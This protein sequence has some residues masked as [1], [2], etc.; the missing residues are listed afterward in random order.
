MRKLVFALLGLWIAH[1]ASAGTVAEFRKAKRAAETY[2]ATANSLKAYV[3]GLGQGM[4]WANIA[5]EAQ[6]EKKLFCP[7]R[8]LALSFD[9]YSS[10]L[11]RE[12]AKPATRD[13]DD[14]GLLLLQGLVDTFP[15]G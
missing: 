1:Y 6:G 8:K 2:P 9:N 3:G 13:T 4:F 7:P 11:D 12:V 10:V 15:C 5:L 14:I